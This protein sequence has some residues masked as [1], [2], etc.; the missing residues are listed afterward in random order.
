MTLLLFLGECCLFAPPTSALSVQDEQEMG[1]EFL[2]NM[3]RQFQF[4]DDEFVSNYINDLGQYLIR[5]LETRYFAFRFY[6]IKENVLNAF[7]A[8]GGHIFIFSGL[9]LAMDDVDE[10]AGVIC[11]EA[12]HVE[13]RHLSQRVAQYKKLGLASMAGILAGVLLGGK[14]GGAVMSGTMAAAMQTQLNYSR[15]D[16]RQADQLGFKYVEASGFDPASMIV[17][18]KKLGQAQWYG[19]NSIPPYL[20]THP[21]PEERMANI[22]TMM[23]GHRPK[24]ANAVTERLREQFPFFKTT[25]AAKCLAPED[26]E[27][28]LNEELKKN[29]AS[30]AAHFGLGIVCTERSEY[31]MAIDHFQKALNA[32]PES[33][34]VLRHLGEVYQFTGRYNEAIT[35]LERALN[36]APEDKASLYFLA[37][38]Y[39]ALE[40][41]RDAIPF[42]ERLTYMEPVRD[43][44]LKNL[45]VCYARENM[46][47]PA[48]YNFGLYFKRVGEV[49]KARYHFEKARE[50]SGDNPSLR[51]R[52][53]EAT[54][55]WL[56]R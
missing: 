45:G 36:I 42:Y 10:L 50:H 40:E 17:T 37:K 15:E 8:P 43:D 25:L 53:E 30:S 47:G 44:V 18:L 26:A 21:G 12:G 48:Y 39:Q 35:L 24:P 55:Q 27:R 56:S 3:R 4:V 20:L 13:A 49:E 6:V 22:E 28:L 2:A 19:G 51:R 52:I 32:D 38:A 14:A 46:M 23:S 41:Y 31:A 9:I 29:P 7:A 1:K 5:P 16:E 33:L 11:H 34:P 54:K